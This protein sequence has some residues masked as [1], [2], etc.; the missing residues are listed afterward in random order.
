[1]KTS[2][3][4]CPILDDAQFDSAVS[5]AQSTLAQFD[6]GL[7]V[8][9]SDQTAIPAHGGAFDLTVCQRL[10]RLSH[11]LT[12]SSLRLFIH[13]WDLQLR[14]LSKGMYLSNR[15]LA[16][17]AG[18]DA[19]SVRAALDQLYSRRAIVLRWGDSA[20]PNR[21][22]V[23]LWEGE[24]RAI[25][26]GGGEGIFPPPKPRIK[27]GG[28][29]IIPPPMAEIEGGVREL[30]PHQ[31]CENAVGIYARGQAR[32][33]SDP[34]RSD[35]DRLPNVENPQAKKPRKPPTNGQ[36]GESEKNAANAA[37]VRRVL[38]ASPGEHH[39]QR[40]IEA[41]QLLHE[42]MR[43]RGERRMLPPDDVVTAQFLACGEWPALQR[44]VMRIIQSGSGR[45]RKYGY[46]V[47]S[48]LEAIHGIAPGDLQQSRDALRP[49]LVQRKPRSI[50]MPQPAAEA[51]PTEEQRAETYGLSAT[52]L[53]VFDELAAGVEQM[54]GEALFRL[55]EE[56][57]A[58]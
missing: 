7:Y 9:R 55:I 8:I 2:S 48:A 28:E 39:A 46:F 52:Q 6:N 29:G 31:Y 21:V 17:H 16:A 4:L 22:Y 5:S 58:K 20:R 3:N 27:G 51:P 41:A 12:N 35:I 38:N 47:A 26:E 24:V 42:A 25:G 14:D 18:L 57:K 23:C 45:I 43:R 13:L 49:Q 10:A 50:N 34:I 54:N 19:K 40:M 15:D 37:L 33:D 11:S 1:M 30:F 44:V 53:R 36:P 56:A 32:L